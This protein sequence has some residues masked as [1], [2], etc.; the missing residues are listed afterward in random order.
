MK[1]YTVQEIGGK[2]Y[3]VKEGESIEKLVKEIQPERTS[4]I[5]AAKVNNILRELTYVFQGDASIEF[6]NLGTIDGVRIYQ[7]SVL[8]VFLRACMELHKNIFVNV[9]HSLSKG[10]Y[11]EIEYD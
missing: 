3:E 7:R 2:A 1:R 10:L 5:I 4:M 8:F 11:C 6:V 9:E